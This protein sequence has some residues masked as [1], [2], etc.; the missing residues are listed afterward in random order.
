[1]VR[2]GHDLVKGGAVARVGKR[3]GIERRRIRAAGIAGMAEADN[4]G[5]IGRGRIAEGQG[6][7]CCLAVGFEVSAAA[8]LSAWRG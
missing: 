2:V 4:G 5:D 6:G 1:M 7:H 3:G 8:G